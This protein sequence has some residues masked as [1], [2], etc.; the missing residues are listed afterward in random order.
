[1]TLLNI[2]AGSKVKFDTC[3]RF[4]GYF[5]SPR[6]NNKGDITAFQYDDPN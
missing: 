6:S 1:M 4:T 3:K 2:E 5:G